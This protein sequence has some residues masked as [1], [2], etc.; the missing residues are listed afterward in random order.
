MR[1]IIV[2]AGHNGLVAAFYLAK[3]GLRPLVLERRA[4]VGG[5]AVTEEIAPGYRSSLA[6]AVGPVRQSVVEDMQLDRRVQLVRP[7]VRVAAVTPDGRALRLF[8]DMG[9]TIES[10]RAFSTDD[11]DRYA[12][13]ASTLER[14]GGFL[15]PL[16]ESTPPSLDRQS[17][18]DWWKILAAG[19][20]FRGLGREDA[21][22]LL[23]WMPMAAA[24]L[25]TEYFS[26]EPL[27]A[28]V[29]TRGIFGTAQGPWS[30]GT[31]AVLLMD[32]ARDPAP[33]GSS[34]SVKGGTGALT[35]AMADAAREAGAEIRT[36][37]GVQ[38]IIVH[39]DR[40]EGVRLDDGSEIAAEN[41]IANT[42]PKRT[43]LELIDPGELDP[44]VRRKATNYRVPGRVAKIDFAIGALPAFKALTEAGD[45][46][47][48]IHIGPTLDYLEHAFD[49]SKYDEIASE[50]YLDVA[51]P[52]VSDPSLAPPGR[53]V[54]SVYV[55]FVPE[56]PAGGR[57]WTDLRERL[58]HIVISTI[59]RYAPGIGRLIEGQRILTPVDLEETYGLTGG[60]IFHG[61]PALDQMFATRPVM[62]WAQY[63]TPVT[64]LF[65]CGAGTHPGGGIT[66]G[67]GQNAAR[68]ITAS[69]K[70]SRSSRGRLS[71]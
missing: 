27:L 10:I 68:E 6:H 65:L 40:V 25:V 21:F 44:S 32:A 63:R 39:G 48:R 34:V 37:A 66:G 29:A 50:P 12:E 62:G 41:V 3:A 14:I 13:F 28:A 8:R 60:H 67:P 69:V 26:S 70:R 16:L 55:Q 17:V 1:P 20:R 43:F 71:T 47:G 33:G 49:P 42:D 2:G 15:R 31:G 53:H 45:L 36:S 54:M 22:R 5:C 51:I 4:M 19:R 23:R 9:R 18:G 7:D 38:R 56:R 35:A 61:E 30:A 46:A 58:A 57:P 11:A 52:S 64:G 59:D 24:D